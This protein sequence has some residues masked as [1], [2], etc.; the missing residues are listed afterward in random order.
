M[1]NFEINTVKSNGVEIEK[2]YYDNWLE[3][4]LKN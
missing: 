1:P 3:R 2:F 4:W